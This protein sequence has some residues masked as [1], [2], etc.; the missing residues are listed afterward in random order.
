[1]KTASRGEQGG[2]EHP[3]RRGVLWPPSP[4]SLPTRFWATE[5]CPG[6]VPNFRGTR[7]M[8][9]VSMYAYPCRNP[10]RADPLMQPTRAPAGPQSP[11]ARPSNARAHREPKSSTHSK[12]CVSTT[13]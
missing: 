12:S 10:L 1:M 8:A 5:S 9:A 13:T 4:E 11:A 6:A 7:E 2:Q 3:L